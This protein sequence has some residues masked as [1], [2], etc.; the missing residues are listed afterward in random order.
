MEPTYVWRGHQ[1]I[2]WGIVPAI[3]RKLGLRPPLTA[4]AKRQESVDH[5]TL[6]LLARARGHGHGRVD[7]RELDDLGLLALLQHS[8]AA[9]PL[10]D[11]TTDPIVALYFAAQP[12][13]SDPD[14]DTD[15]VLLAIDTRRDRCLDLGMDSRASWNVCLR[16]LDEKSRRVGLYTPPLVTPRILAQRGRFVFGA[17]VG[18]VSYAS[19]DLGKHPNWSGAT[20]TA[21]FDPEGG[22]RPTIPPIVGIRVPASEKVR[23]RAVLQNTYGLDAESLFPDLAGFAG[24]NDTTGVRLMT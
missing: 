8:G 11:V 12:S 3:H 24:A 23:L 13:Q 4:A 6:E 17:A 20:L 18:G 7:G 5:E 2:T 19:L 22:G 9:T 16:L 10:L 1:D 15:G 21:L 14:K